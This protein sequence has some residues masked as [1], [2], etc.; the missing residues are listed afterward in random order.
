[1][2]E[3]DVRRVIEA[4]AAEF[5]AMPAE[6][7]DVGRPQAVHKSRPA[8]LAQAPMPL[9]ATP[10]ESM[11]GGVMKMSERPQPFCTRVRTIH[12]DISGQH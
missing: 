4:I 10:M 6:V 2:T 7:A 12:K 11:A 3:W 8:L 1:M 5:A 9:L